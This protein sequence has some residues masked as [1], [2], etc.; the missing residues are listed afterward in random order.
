MI[1]FL[2]TYYLCISHYCHKKCSL[3]QFETTDWVVIFYIWIHLS[4]PM[5]KPAKW[6]VCPAKTQ[7]SLGIRPVSLVFAVRMKKH[8]ALNY[9][10]SAQWRLWLDSADAQADQSLRWAHMSFC[11]FSRAQAHFIIIPTPYPNFEPFDW[12]KKKVLHFD[13]ISELFI[14]RAIISTKKDLMTR[15]E[16]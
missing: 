1:Q 4:R 10:L 3:Q 16:L 9:L 6:P 15:L 11:W 7:I 8:W 14:F 12:L 13:R 5:T 2:H